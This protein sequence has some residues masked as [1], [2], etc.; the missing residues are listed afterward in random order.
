MRCF[1]VPEQKCFSWLLFEPQGLTDELLSLIPSSHLL[2]LCCE[3]LDIFKTVHHVL[4]MF[5]V[6]FHV[7]NE[8]WY[9]WM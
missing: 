3:Y 9:K 8:D 7:Y 2:R 5:S 1:S 4:N 6:L